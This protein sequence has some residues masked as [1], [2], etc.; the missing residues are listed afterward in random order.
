[1]YRYSAIICALLLCGQLCAQTI[2]VRPETNPGGR[3]FTPSETQSPIAYPK[4]SPWLWGADGKPTN[5]LQPRRMVQPVVPQSDTD[6]ISYGGTYSRNEFGISGGVF[7]SPDGSR[8]AVVRKDERDV[9]Q[10]PLLD[11]G[12]RT[13]TLRQIRYPMA[14]MASEKL[15]LCICDTLGNILGEVKADDFEEDRYLTNICW[16]PEGKYIFVQVLSRSQHDLRLNQYR[17]SDG[18]FVR[19]ILS[20]HNDAWVEPTEPIHFVKGSYE[21]IYGTDN[22]D[23][24]YNLYLCDTLGRVQRLT[25]TDADVEYVANDGNWVYYNSTEISPLWNHLFRV[26]VKGGKPG[27]MQQVCPDEEPCLHHKI[28][29][30]PDCRMYIDRISGLDCPGRVQVVDCSGKTGKV[31]EVLQEAE[32]PAQEF[33]MCEVELGQV[34]TADGSDVNYYRFI[35]PAGYDPDKKYPLIVYVY[36]G[37]HSQ[38]VNGSWLGN[39]R[40]WEMAMAQRGYAVYVQDNRGT[41]NRGAAF[42]KAINRQCG[43]AEMADQIAGLESLLDRCPWI[44]RERIGVH[45]WSYGG[46]M[47]TTLFTNHPEYFKVA[48]AGGPVIDWKWYEV[49]YG[50]RYMDTPQT[51]P[52]GFERTS[53]IAKAA[54]VHGKLLI[55]QGAIDDVVVWEHSLSF[56]QECVMKGRQIDYFPYPCDEHNM[57]GKARLHLYDKITEYFLTNL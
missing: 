36:G 55:I 10:F 57:R 9:S 52:E 28:L 25:R 49:M 23:G 37:P 24:W 48:V 5:K 13:G 47:T 54:D 29:M 17:S 32:A 50:E 1:M 38:M 2:A 3:V 42:E 21:F 27:K 46:F 41:D 8:L 11:I 18:S 33:D 4:L 35:K 51:N 44:D 20:E 43:Q 15:G 56:V 53:L 30:K 6:G 40:M 39:I 7:P 16:S 14:G 34:P 12:S 19:T 45:G 26:G 22:R 31:M